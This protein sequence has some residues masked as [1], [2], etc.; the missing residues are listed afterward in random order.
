MSKGEVELKIEAKM[1][2]E[3]E[4]KQNRGKWAMC[5]YEPENYIYGTNYRKSYSLMM[6]NE[7][8]VQN[9]SRGCEVKIFCNNTLHNYL[10]VNHHL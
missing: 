7:V 5:D 2:M 4:I 3:T 9:Y 8:E 1:K 10:T 6:I